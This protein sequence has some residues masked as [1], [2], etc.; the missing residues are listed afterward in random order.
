M[1]VSYQKEGRNYQVEG[2]LNG[3]IEKRLKPKVKQV[4]R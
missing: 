1:E 2:S 4:L 3:I